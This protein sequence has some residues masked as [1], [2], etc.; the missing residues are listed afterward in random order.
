MVDLTNNIINLPII[1]S[2]L[3]KK[4]YDKQGEMVLVLVLNQIVGT[5][6]IIMTAVTSGVGAVQCLRMDITLKFLRVELLVLH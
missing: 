3:V 1:T 5:K 6:D 4:I 2:K